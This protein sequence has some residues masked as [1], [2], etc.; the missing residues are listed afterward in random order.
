MARRRRFRFRAKKVKIG[1]VIAKVVGGVLALYVG[2][3]IHDEIGSV[4]NGSENLFA[5]GLELIGWTVGDY[6]LFNT[7]HWYENCAGDTTT[8]AATAPWSYNLYH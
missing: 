2:G 5:P 1:R 6:S 4:M 7:T 8:Y 3:E